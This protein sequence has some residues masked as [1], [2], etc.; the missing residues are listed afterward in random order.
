MLIR[1]RE[2]FPNILWQPL[3]AAFYLGFVIYLFSLF[4]GNKVTWA[5]GVGA[6]ASSACVV[7]GSP[8]KKAAQIKNL[9]GGYII[10]LFFGLTLHLLSLYLS[11]QAVL[12]YCYINEAWITI[13]VGLTMATMAV[14]N[15]YHPPAVGLSIVVVIDTCS[16]TSAWIIL[17]SVF[18]LILLCK[19]LRSYLIDIF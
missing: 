14:F 13:V 5:V 4:V 10:A 15:L 7:F 2:L 18:L 19:L 9:I 3:L 12:K 1:V 6:L 8:S 16:Y 11:P 17:A